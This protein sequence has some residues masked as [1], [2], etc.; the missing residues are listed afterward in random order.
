MSYF[1]SCAPRVSI[2][3]LVVE[4]EEEMPSHYDELIHDGDDDD[5]NEESLSPL[6]GGTQSVTPIDTD[7]DVS[8]LVF[9]QR[10]HPKYSS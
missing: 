8:S 7:H 9:V 5:Y 6:I 2:L 1:T 10:H 3:E 4:E